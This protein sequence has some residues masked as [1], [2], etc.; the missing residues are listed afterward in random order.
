MRPAPSHR[1]FP[2]LELLWEL[3][4]VEFRL[5]DQGT[6]LGFFWTLLQP[7]LM[8]AVLYALFVRWLGRFVDQYAAYLLIGLV[9]WNFFQKA[10]SVG[11]TSL[12][13]RVA[14]VRNYRFPREIIVMSAVGAVFAST[15]LEIV[16]L[17][18]FLLV[19]GLRPS[20]AWLILPLLCLLLLA[21]ATA[22]S[23]GLALLAAEFRDIERIWEVATAALFYLTPVFY[24]LS[25]VSGWRRR[26]LS[27]SP[28]TMILS[29]TRGCLIDGQAPHPM[30]LAA[31]VALCAALLAA[32]LLWLRRREDRLGDTLLS[33]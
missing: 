2:Y 6:L 5:R 10:T 27:L 18:P 25:I 4:S 20:W 9:L 7:A 29:Q 28:L 1:P 8:F 22:A 30:H 19:M 24:P 3:T 23:I 11:L 31:L 13:R 15:T 32:S 16:V 12:K 14:L 26:L 17:T 33:Y 21:L